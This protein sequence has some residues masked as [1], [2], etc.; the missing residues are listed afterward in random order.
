ME[1]P[2]TPFYFA[3]VYNYSMKKIN[4][5]IL[6]FFIIVLLV[7]AFAVWPQFSMNYGGNE[8]L[9]TY[10]D[11]AGFTFQYPVMLLT[12]YIKTQEWP[13][14]ISMA[15]EKF[16]CDEGEGTA[17]GLPVTRIRRTINH[18]DYCIQTE[19][20]GAAGTT[21]STYRYSTTYNGKLVAVDF[22]LRYPQCL[23]YD[24]PEQS[25]C[26][27]ERENFDLDGLINRIV[28]SIQLSGK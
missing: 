6:A 14:K 11:P 7:I 22:T 18:R 16:G 10:H 17:F 4:F 23:N 13:P 2:A 3:V 19:N 12:K 21:Y 28:G 9:E 1:Y 24:N 5:I 26:L 15:S 25:L 27:K 20:E 8:I